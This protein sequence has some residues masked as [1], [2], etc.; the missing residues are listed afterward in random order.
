M[1]VGTRD[2]KP[3]VLVGFIFMLFLLGATYTTNF[4]K[5]EV[6]AR[7]QQQLLS[8]INLL[9]PYLLDDKG[10][11]VDGLKVEEGLEEQDRLTL[12]DN[13][14]EIIYDSSHE[15]N[16]IGSRK[17]RPEIKAI[18]DGTELDSSSVRASDTIGD[19]YIY[20]AKA[21]YI[22]DNFVGIVRLSQKYT[23]ITLQLRQFQRNL[24]S[25]FLLLSIA[26][27][28]MYVYILR[29]NRKP[30]QFILPIL[31]QAIKNPEKKLAVV[32]A[33]T[34]WQELYHTVYEL[35][36]EN[37]A[38]YNKRMQSEEKMHFLFEQL[39]IG[40]FILNDDLEIVMTN[41][42]A[43]KLFGS[44]RQGPT[45]KEWLQQAKMIRFIEKAQRE[46]R[47]IQGDIVIKR[48]GEH[49]INV[50]IRLLTS[51]NKQEYVGILYDVTAIRQM[52]LVHEDFIS[53]ISHEL[54]TPTTSII[55]FAETLLAGAKDEPEV[56]DDFLGIIEKEGQ[57]LLAL[58]ENIMMLL[59]TE[60]DIHLLDTLNISPTQVIEEEIERYRYRSN[61]KN[62][63][64]VFDSSVTKKI[65]FPGNA[66]QLI[67]K[68][69][70]ENAIAYTDTDGKILMYLKEQEDELVFTIEDTGVGIALEDQERIF[71]RFYRVS[72]SRQRYTGGSGL[73]LSIVQHYTEILNGTV[74]LVSDLGE[75]TTVIVRLPIE[76]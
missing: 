18:L 73:G 30:I 39:D 15:K 68:N 6:I 51:G 14:G 26:V 24:F 61:K 47:D 34:E 36:D 12:L 7:Q 59:K 52:E 63:D 50:A 38:L 27:I 11:N 37:K 13:R 16:A 49:H 21:I 69:L 17:E 2:V 48:G 4:F 64:V 32:D 56:L 76:K 29:Q 67:V 62:I 40:M 46:Q 60:Q 3:H 43:E 44:T 8:E 42:A 65:D 19:K 9:T 74:K 55:G 72:A 10:L 70:L 45:Y 71:E 57:R 25:V 54:K 1:K 5:Q 23:G 35:M 22:G 75:G 41:K 66:F 28:S 20:V 58:I 31:K 33:P 53:N